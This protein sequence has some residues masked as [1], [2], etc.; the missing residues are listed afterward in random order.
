MVEMKRYTETCV[1][2]KSEFIYRECT[3]TSVFFFAFLNFYKE[4][5]PSSTTTKAHLYFTLERLV[6]K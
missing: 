5:T 4:H 1:S 6:G 2:L 3:L